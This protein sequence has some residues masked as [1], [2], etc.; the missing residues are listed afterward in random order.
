MG[1]EFYF[2]NDEL[3]IDIF[4]GL[5]CVYWYISM[6]GSLRLQ[7]FMYKCIKHKS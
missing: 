7:Y 4:N 2:E 5:I 3:Y 6:E 1:C